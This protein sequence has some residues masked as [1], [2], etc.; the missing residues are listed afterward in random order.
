MNFNTIKYEL[1]TI[2]QGEGEVSYGE[3]IQAAASYLLRS[4]ETSA[5]AQRNEPNKAEETKRLIEYINANHL[6]V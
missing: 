6:D 1:Q 4:T 3:S 5:V 2:I